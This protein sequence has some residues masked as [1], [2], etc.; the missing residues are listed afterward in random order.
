MLF[1]VSKRPSPRARQLEHDGHLAGRRAR[2]ADLV[3]V[4]LPEVAGLRLRVPCAERLLEDRPRVRRCRSRTVH[5]LDEDAAGRPGGC[6]GGRTARRGSRLRR[7]SSAADRSGHRPPAGSVSKIGTYS[8]VSAAARCAPALRP[9]TP[10]SKHPGPARSATCTRW[11][12]AGLATKRI[13]SPSPGPMTATSPAC[14]TTSPLVSC[15][16]GKKMRTRSAAP[17]VLEPRGVA[18]RLE[19]LERDAVVVRVV[20]AE[21]PQP[22][23]ADVEQVGGVVDDVV[24]RGGLAVPHAAGPV[25]RGGGGRVVLVEVGQDQRAAAGFAVR[26]DV[27]VGIVQAVDD[28]VAVGVHEQIRDRRDKAHQPAR[29]KLFDEHALSPPIASVTT[30]R[31]KRATTRTDAL[32]G[33]HAHCMLPARGGAD[34]VP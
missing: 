14:G 11:R 21:L 16:V 13:V 18:R 3:A 34:R 6:P 28:A 7:S 25:V 23:P 12:D 22:Q 30:I 17:V 9:S 8:T 33:R 19:E 27:L 10:N 31:Q 24:G 4:L 32:V 1:C 2:V 20:D 15:F 5:V 29:F 26:P